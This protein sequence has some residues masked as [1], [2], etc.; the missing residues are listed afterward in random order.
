MVAT[1]TLEGSLEGLILTSTRSSH[2][3]CTEAGTPSTRLNSRDSSAASPT[4]VAP[5]MT[6][7]LENSTANVSAW[8][9]FVIVKGNVKDSPGPSSTRLKGSSR[10]KVTG[11]NWR[12]VTI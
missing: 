4:D 6:Y 11:L 8:T 9:K 10:A 7:G 1:L 2:G 12:V 5:L 3:R